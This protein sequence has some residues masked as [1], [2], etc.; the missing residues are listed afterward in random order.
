MDVYLYICIKIKR[1][2]IVRI[3]IFIIFLVSQLFAAN[4]DKRQIT[5]KVDALV[6]Q[7]TDLDIFSGNILIAEKGE[8]LYSK[9]FGMANRTTNT[10]N[11][12]NTKFDIG[13]MNKTF[14]KIVILQLAIEGKINLSDTL[15]RFLDGFDLQASKKITIQ[16]L[17]DHQSGFGDY[18]TP[19]YFDWPIS[20]K[21]ISGLLRHIRKLHLM[22]EP[23][24]ESEYSNAGYILLGAIIEKVSRKSYYQNVNERIVMPLNLKDTY[25]ENIE[26]V[27]DRSIGYF[28]DF[29]GE[30]E[31]NE[32]FDEIP[33]P[34]GGFLSTT[35]DIFTFY[36]SFFYGNELLNEQARKLDSLF[37]KEKEH[38]NNDIGIIHAGGFEGANT[39]FS[40]ILR[41]KISIIVFA[42][43]NEPVAELL[44]IGIRDII[45]GREPQKPALPAIQNI[46][47][48]LNESGF[49]YIKN[50][51]DALTV[52]FPFGDP[53]D[54]ILNQL[55]YELL[56]EEDIENAVKLFR[57]NTNLFPT[58]PNCWDSFGESL[59][60]TGDKK[61]SL[62][63]YKKALELDP[64]FP[65][66][67]KAVQKLENGK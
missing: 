39:A 37:N 6:K 15:G 56:N 57:L 61:G 46:Y 65:S 2:I 63:A 60:L 54:L 42:N 10:L 18:F 19:D 20:E 36:K 44:A 67:I 11:T 50:N 66:A 24:T 21:T 55:G 29:K 23:G 32:R 8:M 51:F 22:F 38:W 25:L 40:E 53:K 13:S 41:D 26:Q 7:Y 43:M 17:L 16:H 14:T 28:K 45:N 33:S 48:A 47:K 62:E 3:F 59:L 34:A 30:L 27:P 4:I 9:S 52:N 12:L 1:R 58:E 64:Q 31:S 49:E 5:I 35:N